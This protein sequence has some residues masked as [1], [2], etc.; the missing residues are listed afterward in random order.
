MNPT[1]QIQSRLS[2]FH[3]SIL[4]F[5]IMVATLACVFALEMVLPSAALA[6]FLET[7]DTS[8][9][10]WQRF[11]SDCHVPKQQWKQTRSNEVELRNRF[12]K[13]EFDCGAGTRLMVA[14]AVPPAM[15]IS[16]LKPSVRIKASRTGV[17]LW[18]RVVLPHVPSPNGDGPLTTLLLGPAYDQTG[19]WQTIGFNEQNSKTFNLQTQLTEQLWLLRNKLGGNGK[20][21]LARD[22]YILSLI[23]ISEP[24]RPY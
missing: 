7:F 5:Q 22:A 2:T 16:D 10:T 1:F 6:Q 9:P 4:R 21:I 8:T 18:V 3:R 14:H 17:Q 20:D 23:H 19:N 11:E 15:V 24:T 13:I 12:E